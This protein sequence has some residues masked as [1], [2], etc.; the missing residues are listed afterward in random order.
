MHGNASTVES[1]NECERELDIDSKA[2]G[3]MQARK[4]KDGEATVPKAQPSNRG[5]RDAVVSFFFLSGSHSQ[6]H[7]KGKEPDSLVMSPLS[8]ELEQHIKDKIG[9]EDPSFEGHTEEAGP[10]LEQTKQYD[11][12][13]QSGPLAVC[14][15]G[16]NAGHSALR[17]LSQSGATL[18]EFD[19]GGHNYSQIGADYLMSKYPGRLNVFWGD[20]TKTMP[21]FRANHSGVKCDLMIVDGGHGY[22][23]ARSDLLNFA[24]MAK[25]DAILAI[26]DAPCAPSWCEGPQQAWDELVQHGCITAPKAVPMG[27]DRGFSYGRVASC[28]LF[29]EFESEAA[30]KMQEQE[31]AALTVNETLKPL[32]AE[33]EKHIT[34]LLGNVTDGGFEGHTENFGP[35]L[36]QTVQ[37]DQWAKSGFETICETGFNAGHS[38][39]R[40]LAQSAANLYEFDLGEHVYSKYAEE[41]LMDKYPGRL[42]VFWGDSTKTMP[43]FRANQSDVKCDLM[44]VDGGHKYSVAKSD[45]LNFAMMSKPNGLIA[46]DDAPCNPIWCEGPQQAW[47]ELVQHGCISAVKAVPM[48]LNRGF[49]YGQFTP[50][51]F[52]MPLKQ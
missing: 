35:Q 30:D 28:S 11:L 36:K 25:P 2:S 6:V 43:A 23:I 4:W 37:Y 14:E 29:T 52:P 27:P 41:H 12:W 5:L 3:L 38:A 46:I 17:F 50:C 42:N 31:A 51:V 45:L 8:E 1:S 20:S 21:A 32:Y 26:D 10:Q 13:A 7:K 39:L 16:F 48:G 34:R 40:F 33:L 47:D 22:P 19:L 44:I 9:S 49:T 18:Y 24:L 15:T